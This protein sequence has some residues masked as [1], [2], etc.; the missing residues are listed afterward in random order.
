[1]LNADLNIFRLPELFSFYYFSKK[2]VLNIRK[3]F[4]YVKKLQFKILRKKMVALSHYN[5]LKVFTKS[6]N[7]SNLLHLS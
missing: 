7:Y 2:T 5:K 3:I 4:L 6:S 1:M